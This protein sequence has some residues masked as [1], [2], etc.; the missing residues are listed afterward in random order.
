MRASAF[1]HE[2]DAAHGGDVGQA[3][4]LG[5]D[6]L[7]AFQALVQVSQELLQPGDA[8]L[9]QLALTSRYYTV[10]AAVDYAGSEAVMTSLLEQGAAGAFRL[11]ARRWTT[12]E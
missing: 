6:E 7:S 9:G 1:H 4:A 11:A 12:E 10:E 3:E 5:G 2:R 8:A